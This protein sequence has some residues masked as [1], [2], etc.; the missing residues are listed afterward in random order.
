MPERSPWAWVSGARQRENNAIAL[1][2]T[3]NYTALLREFPS[4]L[5][6][7]S[8]RR[9]GLPNGLM[10]NSEVGHLNI[11]AGRVVYQDFTRIDQAI[12][13]GEFARNPVLADA[14]RAARDG[15]RALHVLGLLAP[16][17]GVVIFVGC[18]VALGDRRQLGNPGLP[19]AIPYRGHDDQRNSQKDQ[20]VTVN[21]VAPFSLIATQ[22]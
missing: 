14:V 6:Y 4:T 16:P 13:S 3:P 22:L 21:A 20:G 19:D 2:R 9:V 7:T 1:A 12:A 15:G 11:G 8:G 5:V 17:A 18:F 10:G